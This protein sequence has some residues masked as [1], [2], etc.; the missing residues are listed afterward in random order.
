[1][2]T[3][4]PLCCCRRLIGLGHRLPRALQIRLLA[5][6]WQRMSARVGEQLFADLSRG[7]RMYF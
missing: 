7:L 6:L 2:L 4:L 1:M 5:E 3:F